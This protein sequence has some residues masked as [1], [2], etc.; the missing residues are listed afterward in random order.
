MR[1]LNF[2][3]YLLTVFLVGVTMY[4]SLCGQSLDSTRVSID[5]DPESW[6]RSLENLSKDLGVKIT[7]QDSTTI[8]PES[9]SY[10]NQ[11]LG[12]VLRDLLY[13][14]D[15]S[16]L[17]YRDY[18][19]VIG[20]KTALGESKSASFYQALQHNL[21]GSNKQSDDLEIVI[22]DINHVLSA[23]VTMV[24]GNIVDRDTNEPIIGATIFVK[25]TGQGTDS[26]EN[27]QF[28]LSLT[29]GSYTLL[30]QYIGFQDRQ[31]PVR[32][33][34][35]GMLDIAL[36]R[37][38][39]LLD[40]VVVEAKKRD[41]NIQSVEVG[42]SR[43]NMREIEK[44]PSFL[45]EVDIIKGLL[46]Q[47][48]VSTIGEGSSGFNVRGGTVDQNLI[49]VD[50]GMIFNASHA[51][52]FFSAFNSD[53]LSDAILYKGNIP[54]K[55]GGRLA[56]VLDVNVKD[57]NF[58]K[59]RFKGGLG[60]VS[61]RLSLEGPLKKDK[62]SFLISGRSTYSDWVLKTVKIPEVSTSSAF[63]YDVNVKLTHRF[64]E[65]NF[66]SFSGYSTEDQFTYADE[67]GFDYQSILGQ[68]NYRSVLS[69]R[70]FST[71]SIIL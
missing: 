50:E 53:I 3:C 29:P 43:V 16:F 71:L 19:M 20:D 6:Q 69:D 49:V 21:G 33:V 11:Y 62:T 52:G 7:V 39:I 66:V 51:L 17:I 61:S 70:L 5:L 54:A 64:N 58:Q 44:L 1:E 60:V 22:G 63:F 56:S 45:G 41:E 28:Q 34:S 38:S 30:I 46:Q 25:E 27:G 31:I 32:I 12:D 55:F 8:L 4:G 18:L 10:Q 47:P 23:D 68:I 67:F 13:G 26:D 24:T 40:E 57:G 48:G 2:R 65:R 15:L 59:L 35:S 42:V 37:S 14:T 9:K 36:N